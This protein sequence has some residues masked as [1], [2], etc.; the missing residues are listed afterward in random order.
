MKP[1][2]FS[3]LNHFTVPCVAM[4]FVFLG[5]LSRR[6]GVSTR[7]AGDVINIHSVASGGAKRTA[8]S[9]GRTNPRDTAR[10]AGATREKVEPVL[11]HSRRA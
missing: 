9:L 6:A 3:E 7:Q 8:I 2:P 4:L 10:Q 1:K 5:L 11:S